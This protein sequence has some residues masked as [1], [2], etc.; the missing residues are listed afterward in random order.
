METPVVA[1]DS[2]DGKTPNASVSAWVSPEAEELEGHPA[3]LSQ[4]R[5]GAFLFLLGSALSVAA[6]ILFSSTGYLRLSIP[7]PGTYSSG[8]VSTSLFVPFTFLVGLTFSFVAFWFYHDG[9]AALRTLDE[10]FRWSPS[11]AWL[12]I[13]GIVLVLV[14]LAALDLAL[15]A[16]VLYFGLGLL[17]LGTVL[18]L[19]GVIGI[20]VGLWRMGVRYHESL[21]QVG[22]FL[23]LLPFL[24][25]VGQLLVLWGST[26]VRSR[27][28]PDRISPGG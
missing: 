28:L 27:I 16:F 3:G 11:F 7:S 19:V 10:R 4:V 5:T 9:F 2:L 25:L 12:A 26:R 14:G 1:E 20:L 24:S 15:F 17:A 23:T 6:P 22:A 21:F 8:I 18:I 13:I